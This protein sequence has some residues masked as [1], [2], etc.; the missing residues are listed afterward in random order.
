M[1]YYLVIK[2]KRKALT[3]TPLY[4]HETNN[5]ATSTQTQT[6]TRRKPDPELQAV[7]KEIRALIARSEVALGKDNFTALG[8]E[9]I[10]VR[11]RRRDI[12]ADDAAARLAYAVTQYQERL[13]IRQLSYAD[14][15]VAMGMPAGD[16]FAPV[17]EDDEE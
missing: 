12:T 9:R 1:V 15:G 4:A 3:L 2:R 14:F 16:P 11:I 10:L 7:A 8:L 5:M 17:P 6:R 13:I